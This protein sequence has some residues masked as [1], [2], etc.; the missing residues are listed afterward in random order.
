MLSEHSGY[1]SPPAQPP[2]SFLEISE[3]TFVWAAKLN[4]PPSCQGIGKAVRGKGKGESGGRSRGK[5]GGRKRAS[6]PG[7]QALSLSYS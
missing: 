7:G 3:R 5:E 1:K 4:L 2:A 6:N